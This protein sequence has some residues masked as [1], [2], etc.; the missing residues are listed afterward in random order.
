MSPSATSL[1]LSCLGKLEVLIWA[2]SLMG[3]QSPH[4][5]FKFQHRGKTESSVTCDRDCRD[6]AGQDPGGSNALHAVKTCLRLSFPLS[7]DIY[8]GRGLCSPWGSHL[9]CS[10]LVWDSRGKR[11]TVSSAFWQK[12]E[13]LTPVLRTFVIYR[14]LI[15]F[16]FVNFRFIEV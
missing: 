9:T 8:P 16:L 7:V 3:R 1:Q 10:K 5:L 12:Q 4:C 11:A 15:F 6:G 14:W 13:M 2:E